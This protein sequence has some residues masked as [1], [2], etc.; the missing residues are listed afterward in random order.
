VAHCLVN[1]N[2]S[3]HLV[4]VLVSTEFVMCPAINYPASR[5]ISTVVRF[6]QAK[7]MSAE[8]ILNELSSI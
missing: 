4:F 3:G 1:H 5:K 6:L 2:V 8:E 7:N